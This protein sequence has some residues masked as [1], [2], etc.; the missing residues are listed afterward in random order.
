MHPYYNYYLTYNQL[1][2]I[3]DAVAL[4]NQAEL[5]IHEC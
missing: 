2:R 1:I 5:A 4:I 3:S